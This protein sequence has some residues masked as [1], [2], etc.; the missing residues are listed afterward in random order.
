MLG[1]FFGYRKFAYINS[2]DKPISK[3]LGDFF[4]SRKAAFHLFV[5]NI[6]MARTFIHGN[7]KKKLDETFGFPT[8]DVMDF[9]QNYIKKIKNELTGMPQFLKAVGFF[10]Q[11]GTPEKMMNFICEADAISIQQKYTGKNVKSNSNNSQ[12]QF[13]NRPPMKFKRY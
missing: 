6:Q 4:N 2:P 5:F 13:N 3:C 10:D 8:E 11:I 7:G 12:Q 1:K 9:F